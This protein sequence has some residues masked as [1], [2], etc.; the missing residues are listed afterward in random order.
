MSRGRPNGSCLLSSHFIKETYPNE[1]I[2]ITYNVRV[3]C[4]LSVTFNSPFDNEYFH[5]VALRVSSV[6]RPSVLCCVACL[7]QTISPSN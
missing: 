6:N 4:G 1:S 5:Y 3:F 7:P 2:I